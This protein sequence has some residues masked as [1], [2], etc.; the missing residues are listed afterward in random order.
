MSDRVSREWD[1]T[2]TSMPA[3]VARRTRR[4]SSSD[5]P[6][7]MGPAM[8]VRRPVSVIVDGDAFGF[9]IDRGLGLPA[10]LLEV[11]LELLRAVVVFELPPDEPARTLLLCEVERLIEGH[12]ILEV[13]GLL[14]IIG[15]VLVVVDDLAR[16]R[17]DLDIVVGRAVV[18]RHLVL[19]GAV[20][21]VPILFDAVHD[22]VAGLLQRRLDR[23]LGAH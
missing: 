5:L 7:N 18:Y 21:L 2:R 3:I 17:V 1:T 15:A 22:A 10:V 9:D 20:G 11:E 6:E 14:L 8:T 13:D 16:L 19:P 4:M 12:R 23:V